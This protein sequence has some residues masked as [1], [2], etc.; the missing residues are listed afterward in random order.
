VFVGGSAAAEEA[1][2]FGA[3]VPEFVA[4]AEQFNSLA[5]CVAWRRPGRSFAAQ[6]VIAAWIS[7][8]SSAVTFSKGVRSFIPIL[9]SRI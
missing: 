4:L 5:T 1:E 2:G 3:G 9:K 6:V 8:P 7:S